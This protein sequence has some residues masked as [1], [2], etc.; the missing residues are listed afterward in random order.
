MRSNKCQP[1]DNTKN[2]SILFFADIN[3]CVTGKHNCDANHTYCNNT[4]GSFACLCE[5]GYTGDGLNCTGNKT[6]MFR[7]QE[8]NEY[9]SSRVEFISEKRQLRSVRKHNRLRGYTGKGQN[10]LLR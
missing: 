7:Y 6:K 1:S 8:S 4:K 3:E 2:M 9:Q 5:P 10:D